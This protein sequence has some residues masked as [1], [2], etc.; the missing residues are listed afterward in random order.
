MLFSGLEGEHKHAPAFFVRGLPHNSAGHLAHVV[1]LHGHETNVR[2][3][4]AKRQ[5]KGLAV[6]NR[7]I[8]TPFSG[9]LDYGKGRRVTVFNHEGF[10]GMDGLRE[11]GV[12]F[13]YAVT[14][15]GRK[16]YACN[17]LGEGRLEGFGR[18]LAFRC[19]NITQIYAVEF[20]IG[21]HYLYYMR[22]KGL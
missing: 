5:S 19:V 13:H 2:A 11:S 15:Y 22:Q 7:Y 12:V 3:S 10:C 1:L 18:S 17:V 8:G 21:L 4:V 20:C 6:A 14:V 16:D 9:G